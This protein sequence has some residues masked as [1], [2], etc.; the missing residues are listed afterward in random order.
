MANQESDERTPTPKK[1]KHKHYKNGMRALMEIQKYQKNNDL[2]ILKQPLSELVREI[3]QDM[4]KGEKQSSFCWTGAVMLAIHTALE[5]YM[6][7]VFATANDNAIH[8]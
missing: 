4:L 8:G 3:S 1:N 7:K 5:D 6:V 2:L